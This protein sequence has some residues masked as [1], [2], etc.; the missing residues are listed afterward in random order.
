MA[1]TYQQALA[2][3]QGPI[4]SQ[5]PF[6]SRVLRPSNWNN[7][8]GGLKAQYLGQIEGAMQDPVGFTINRLQNDVAGYVINSNL[9][10]GTGQAEAADYK[11]NLQTEVNFLIS[12]KVPVSDIKSSIESGQQTGITSLRDQYKRKT[13][14]AWYDKV[15]NVSNALM[16]G[17]L[18]GGLGL[19]PYQQTLLNSA[20]QLAA[21]AKPEDVL[22][23]AAG[24]LTAA[25]IPKYLA[26]VS[27]FGDLP[28]TAYTALENASR[29]VTNALI[30]KQDPKT[31]MLAGAAGGAV[32]G[33]LASDNA[34]IARAAGEYTQALAAGMTQEQAL[35]K[36]LS[37]FVAAEQSAAKQKVLDSAAQDQKT[38]TTETTSTKTPTTTPTTTPA[39][40]TTPTTTTTTTTDDKSLPPV[41]VT[42]AADPNKAILDLISPTTQITTPEIK[43]PSLPEVTVTATA[44][45]TAGNL[46][47]ISSSDTGTKEQAKT[48]T[49]TRDSIL[50]S[51][52]NQPM[53]A[54]YLGSQKTTTPTQTQLTYGPGSQALAQALRIGDAGAPIFG[55]DKEKSKRSGWNVESLRYMGNSEV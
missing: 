48:T 49:P 31:A 29:Q 24:T 16:V 45:N 53:N 8:N 42:A 46:S 1:I 55:G 35:N 52:L 15:F 54:Q 37:G 11:N 34:A 10:G 14:Q 18:T 13:D 50:L 51:L 26:Q 12:Q 43:N 27:A 22:R 36:A 41:T 5:I 28:D 7:L 6:V 4:G 47:T 19:A 32:T 30:T 17:G 9:G 40:A 20:I 21:G 23:A 33:F 44:D 38:T 25:Q 39:T 3:S 2:F